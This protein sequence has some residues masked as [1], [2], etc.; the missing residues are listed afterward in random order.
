M[1]VPKKR[2]SQK[3]SAQVKAG[4]KKLQFMSITA[5]PNCKAPSVSHRVCSFCGYYNG[6]VYASLAKKEKAKKES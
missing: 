5:C 4:K 1:A 2:S 3:K 6:R